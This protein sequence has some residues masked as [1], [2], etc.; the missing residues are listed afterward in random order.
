VRGFVFLGAPLLLAANKQHHTLTRGSIRAILRLRKR[1]A[2]RNAAINVGRRTQ[3][4]EG[5]QH[6]AV[7]FLCR[8]GFLQT[9]TNTAG[10]T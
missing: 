3:Q 7:S 6:L 4:H 9:G 8:K 1:H 2:I 5:G 10:L